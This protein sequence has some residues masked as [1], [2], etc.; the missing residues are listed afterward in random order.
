MITN[1]HFC[2]YL[3]LKVR[4]R[5][6]NFEILS[7]ISVSVQ[8]FSE[9]LEPSKIIIRLQFLKEFLDRKRFSVYY[10]MVY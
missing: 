10:F 2:R 8:E 4:S 6:K 7:G 3:Y 5:D 1:K 9:F